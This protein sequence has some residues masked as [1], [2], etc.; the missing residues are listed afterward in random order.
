MALPSP[1]PTL[2]HTRLLWT[3]A[4][5][6]NVCLPQSLL[7]IVPECAVACIQNFASA[8]YPGSTCSAISDINF[9]CTQ[10]N[11]SGLTIGEGSL[12]CVVSFCTGQELVNTKVYNICD[13]VAGAQPET[14]RTITATIIGSSPTSS[15]MNNLPATIGNP[16]SSQ[17]I[18]T[19]V[20]ATDTPPSTTPFS[21]SSLPSPS[22]SLTA[23][24]SAST[25][26][27]SS[28]QG[29]TG[30]VGLRGHSASEGGLRTTQVVGIAIAGAATVLI[31]LALLMLAFCI[32]KRRRERR[33][34]QRRS[35]LVEPTPPPNYQSPP[36]SSPP[37]FGN[38]NSSLTVSSPQG[39][40]YSSPQPMEE[41]RRSFWRRSIRPEE[42]GVAISPKIPGESS[43][44]SISSQQSGSRLLSSAPA[45]ALWPAPLDI[46]ASRE[47]QRASQRPMSDATDFDDEPQTRF[48][49]SEPVYVD[50]QPFVLEKPPPARRQ[51]ATP[52]PLRLPAVPEDS[53]G[54]ASK[55][56]RIPLTPTYDNG[57]I[58]IIPPQRIFGSPL[59]SGANRE[60][61]LQ[62]A[63]QFSFPVAE[64]KL[65]PS[66][67]YASRNVL[68]KKPPTRLPLRAF[69]FQPVEAL[70]QP[71][72]PPPPPM[73]NTA[74]RL[75]RGNS[76]TSIY[77]EIEE[78]TPPGETNK[79]LELEAIVRTP[80]V[81]SKD[82]HRVLPGESSPIKDLRYPQIPRSAAMSRQA[83]IPAQFQESLTVAPT[84]AASRASRDQ[85]V[86]AEASFMQTDT[87]SS[88]GY[89]SDETIEWPQPPLY[90]TG[91]SRG[92]RIP[93]DTLKSNVA[94]L[95][96]TP[97]GS[98]RGLPSSMFSPSLGEVLNSSSQS[99]KAS[100]PQRSPSSKARLT[101]NKSS[102]GDLY[103]TVEI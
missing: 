28:P 63:S 65:A 55:P 44:V 5:A 101:P 41:K 103:L 66:S 18:S 51:R 33:R 75:E 14:A 40:F 72:N 92:T 54:R 97:T 68:R 21:P 31:V 15:T 8:N 49:D 56:A 39:R 43:P 48:A 38:I 27:V 73:P 34:S 62:T 16:T 3:R 20:M 90:E 36:K 13:G 99:V 6:T 52:T 32:R 61:P 47:R 17:V 93:Q 30:A 2:E 89:L 46:E 80:T 9:L 85:L 71:R 10:E 76:V 1:A 74:P 79:Q 84:N 35:R 95:R 83:E 4:D 77:T 23:M 67:A 81:F 22:A 7:S 91:S 64:H 11:R 12:Q 42:I 26:A 96:S 29:T 82:V 86:R 58:S 70:T 57:N 69:D 100:G 50:N 60:E 94:K 102:R 87:T 37:T 24:T 25:S 88:D 53:P 19:I 98:N 45:K 78:D 59:S